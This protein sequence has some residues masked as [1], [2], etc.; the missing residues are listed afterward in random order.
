M[1][2]EF[3]PSHDDQ[4]RW[5]CN[6]CPAFGRRVVRKDRAMKAGQ[7]HR[8]KVDGI[9]GRGGAPWILSN[10]RPA[11]I[12]RAE[13]VGFVLFGVPFVVLFSWAHKWDPIAILA[14]TMI[15]LPFLG[16]VGASL[17]GTLWRVRLA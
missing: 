3:E 5:F 6:K 2:I 13:V 1:G 12:R 17:A 7:R 4:G 8:C 14:S 10:D 9:A 11:R 15:G 16:A